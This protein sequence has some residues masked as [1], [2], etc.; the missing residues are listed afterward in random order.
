MRSLLLLALAASFA[1][2]VGSTKP[3]GDNTECEFRK[4]TYQHALKQS[5]KRAPLLPIFDALELATMCGQKRP[6][7]RDTPY[8]P[9][10]YDVR[11]GDRVFFVDGETG[12]D[13][14]SGSF[15]H[16]F[17]SVAKAVETSREPSNKTSTIILR[18]GQH[19]LK[20]TIVLGPKDKGLTIQNF[21]SEEGKSTVVKL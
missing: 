2:H 17:A 14:N 10:A 8:W 9:Q 6:A 20:E 18:A 15:A 19:Y 13:T 16:P 21:K 4:L 5:P 1:A 7:P 12:E 3:A 11:K